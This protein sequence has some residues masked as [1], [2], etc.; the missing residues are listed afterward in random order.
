MLNALSIS[1]LCFGTVFKKLP[2]VLNIM[3]RTIAMGHFHYSNCFVRKHSSSAW[4]PESYSIN[5]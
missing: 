2:I 3:P 1:Y 4:L 5:K